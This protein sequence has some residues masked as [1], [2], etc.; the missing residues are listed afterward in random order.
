MLVEGSSD[1]GLRVKW[2]DDVGA[3]MKRSGEVGRR[4]LG[5]EMKCCGDERVGEKK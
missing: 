1:V 5:V 2:G 4:M 3:Q